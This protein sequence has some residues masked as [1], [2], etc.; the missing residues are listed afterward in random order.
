MEAVALPFRQPL[1]VLPPPLGRVAHRNRLVTVIGR[2]SLPQTP[3]HLARAAYLVGKAWPE[4][5]F[6]LALGRASCADELRRLANE[7]DVL[8]V[9]SLPPGLSPQALFRLPPTL[10][11]VVSRQVDQRAVPF[12]ALRADIWDPRRLAEAIIRQLDASLHRPMPAA[13]HS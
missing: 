7:A 2:P 12:E 11:L 5:R 6:K 8:V 4:A 13:L 10:P 1:A 3:E 9:E